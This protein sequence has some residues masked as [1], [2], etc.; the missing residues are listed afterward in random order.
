MY[1]WTVAILSIRIVLWHFLRFLIC[2]VPSNRPC[3]HRTSL[4]IP[5]GCSEAVNWRTDN[6]MAKRKRTNLHRENTTEKTIH[7]TRRTSLKGK[8]ELR[9]P[10]RVSRSCSTIFMWHHCIAKVTETINGF[11]CLTYQYIHWLP[12]FIL[13]KVSFSNDWLSLWISI[14]T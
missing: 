2:I 11:L 3:D 1:Y 12:P 9:S 5:K 7:H 8:G 4:K 6:T 14:F 13:N 10:G